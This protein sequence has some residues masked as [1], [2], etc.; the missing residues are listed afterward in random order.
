MLPAALA[1]TAIGAYLTARWKLNADYTLLGARLRTQRIF[2]KRWNVGRGNSF[3][4]LEEHANNPKVANETFLIFEGRTWTFKQFYD[5]VLHYAGWLHSTHNVVAGEIVALDFMNSPTFLCLIVALWSLGA[6]PALLNYGL[7]SKPLIHCVKISTARLLIVEPEVAARALTDET[8]EAFLAPNFR[9]NAFPLDIVVLDHGLESS[10]QHFPPYRAPNAARD[11][12]DALEIAVLMFTSG[13]TGLPKAAIVPWTKTQ[14][15]AMISSRI[16][17]LRSVTH[18]KPDR[19]YASMPLYHNTAFTLSFQSCLLD[20]VTMIIGRKFS[21][22][23]FWPEVRQTKATVILYVG[24][25]LRY[26]LAIPPSAD[27]LNNDVRIAY[28][29]GLRPEVWKRFRTRYGIDI[30]VE[31]YGSTEGPTATWNYNRNGFTDGAVGSFGIVTQFLATKLIKFV[32]VDW[33][34]EAPW[35]DPKTGLCQQ[36]ATGENG[37]FVVKVDPADIRISF[38]GYYGNKDATDSKIIRDV[39]EKDD[40]YY[41]TGDVMKLDKDGRVWFT[42]RIGDTYRWRSENVSTNEVGDVVGSHDLVH[43]ANVYGV[44][45]PGHE[46]RAGC[47]ALHLHDSALIKGDDDIEARPEILESLATLASNTLP[48]HAVPVFLRLVKEPLTT[49]NNKQLKS[50]LRKEGV[51]LKSIAANGS[52]DRMYWL[53]PG[54]NTY[55]DFRQEDLDTLEAGKAR[56]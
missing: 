18:K 40:A 25:T 9:N 29:N 30:I 43:E 13:T 47:A 17:G 34:T 24:E 22:S 20:A 8:K 49:G 14:A 55:V 51:D 4:T 6:H 36:V 26:L 23:R 42:D 31:I 1:A 2:D 19:F 46:G 32:K 27:D 16:L 52:N 33:E 45:V 28:G 15:G 11:V 39:L 44:K 35:R 5:Q 12:K 48:K 53:K 41:R 37:E 7:T 54:A 21:V 3:Y 10:L 56:L 38:S 50:G